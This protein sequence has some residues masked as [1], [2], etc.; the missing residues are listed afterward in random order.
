MDRDY[1]FGGFILKVPRRDWNVFIFKGNNELAE[2]RSETASIVVT[3]LIGNYNSLDAAALASA[4]KR[5]SILQSHRLRTSG[6]ITGLKT[7]YGDTAPYR[8]IREI[9]YIYPARDGGF[10]CFHAKAIARYPD[11]QQA[12]KFATGYLRYEKVKYKSP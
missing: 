3:R 12:N 2:F 1:R 8:A 6:A 5:L 9:C 10:V 11:W 7:V 4:P